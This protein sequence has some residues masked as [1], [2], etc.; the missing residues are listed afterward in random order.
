MLVLLFSIIA[1]VFITFFRC[2]FQECEAI[3]NLKPQS[4]FSLLTVAFALNFSIIW[5]VII[6]LRSEKKFH[7][8]QENAFIKGQA[9][10]LM[11]SKPVE[12]D[13][14]KA[15]LVEKFIDFLDKR[16]TAD[17]VMGTKT[18]SIRPREIIDNLINRLMPN[19]VA[20][21]PIRNDKEPHQSPGEFWAGTAPTRNYGQPH[22]SPIYNDLY[23]I[24]GWTRHR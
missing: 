17:I 14:D 12:G 23:N 7:A 5:Y 4:V 22:L 18:L 20:A 16:Y 21:S 10:D 24:S 15:D 6:C 1:A 19:Q 2:Y 13:K 9:I 11:L 8:L 3:I